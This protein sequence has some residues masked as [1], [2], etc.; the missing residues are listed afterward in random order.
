MIDE[1][2]TSRRTFLKALS[3]FGVAIALPPVT[4]QATH[5]LVI[6][7]A[8]VIDEVLIDAPITEENP[9]GLVILNENR[10]KVRRLDVRRQNEQVEIM[11]SSVRLL[12][13]VAISFDC[14]DRY[15]V[16]RE[17]LRKAEKVEFEIRIPGWD[18]LLTGEA[19]IV[20]TSTGTGLISVDMIVNGPLSVIV[21]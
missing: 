18:N 13:R 7:S 4:P 11:E 3:A 12:H 8:Q 10:I 9:F 17:L 5:G 16:I 2:K 6:P 14:D 15:D 21:I 20:G 1:L 19:Y